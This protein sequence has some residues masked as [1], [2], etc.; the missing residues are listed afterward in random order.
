MTDL[1]PACYQN[2]PS[3]AQRLESAVG[4]HAD[5]LK[6]CF[7]SPTGRRGAHDRMIKLRRTRDYEVQSFEYSANN[8]V[9]FH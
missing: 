8:I 9:K 2:T 4:I 6:F 5:S 7:S 3:D 1:Y